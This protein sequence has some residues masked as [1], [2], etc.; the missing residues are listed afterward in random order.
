M[1]LRWRDGMSGL[2]GTRQRGEGEGLIAVAF[3]NAEEPDALDGEQLV[4]RRLNVGAHMPGKLPRRC[5]QP[6]PSDTGEM[7]FN[8]G[9]GKVEPLCFR[10]GAEFLCS[11]QHAVVADQRRLADQSERVLGKL[12]AQLAA[13]IADVFAGLGRHRQLMARR[14]DSLL[15]SLQERLSDSA[16]IR[17]ANRFAPL[18][19]CDHHLNG[20]GWR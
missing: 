17:A 20:I 6:I 4:H 3:L 14:P 9:T 16:R 1:V 2:S 19:D 5:D 10:D 11:C 18:F 7:P 15:C 13:I 8:G 12:A